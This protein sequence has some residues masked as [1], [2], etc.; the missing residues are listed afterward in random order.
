MLTLQGECIICHSCH[1]PYWFRGAFE[2]T[3]C[4][5]LTPATTGSGLAPSGAETRGQD[6][7]ALSLALLHAVPIF[8][9]DKLAA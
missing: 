4:R 8:P 9:A 7:A 5:G 1:H 3:A 6:D 2:A